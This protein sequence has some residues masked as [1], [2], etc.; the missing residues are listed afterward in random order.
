MKPSKNHNNRRLHNWIVYNLFDK[1]LDK[2]NR[3]WEAETDGY[4]VLARKK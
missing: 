4:F 2:L 1:Y 3:N